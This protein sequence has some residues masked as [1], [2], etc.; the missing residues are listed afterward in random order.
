MFPQVYTPTQGV[1]NNAYVQ[2]QFANPSSVSA[3][4]C[5]NYSIIKTG[6]VLWGPAYIS[7]SSEAKITNPTTGET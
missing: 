4:K 5:L 7:I 6:A 3:S 1:W 2:V